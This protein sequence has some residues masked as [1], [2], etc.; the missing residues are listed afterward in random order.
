MSNDEE[1]AMEVARPTNGIARRGFGTAEI[2]H[3]RETQGSA[4]AARAQAEV[5]AR[6]IMAE[7]KP[8]NLETFRVKL[9]EH[10]KRQG[11]AL[12]AEYSK[13]VGGAPIKGP[14][15]RFVETALREYTNTLP[16]ETITYDDD[17]KRVIRVSVTDL[18][19][20]VTY[21]GD[22]VVEKTVERKK[23]K[24]S[25][26]IMSSRTN[27]YGDIVFKVRATE[28]D[29]ANK[30]A[31]ACSKKLRNLGLRI[32]PADIVDD[33]MEACR[34]TRQAKDA[35]DPVAARRS[36]IDAFAALGV[37]PIGL[38]EYLGHPF[39]QASPAEMDELRA[40]YATVKDGEAKWVDIVE[41]QRVRRGEVDKGSKDSETA[42]AKVKAKLEA[43]KAKRAES[44]PVINAE[45]TEGGK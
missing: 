5:Q 38:D 45:S 34:K 3:R 36:I 19:C 25:D 44:K 9:L 28:D 22:V 26:E 11:F 43:V 33:A 30:A 39:D 18:E 32:L 8:R 31:A 27:S 15:I 20:N 2:E 1:Q 23:P 4:L 12:V 10:C 17:H 6:Y 21:Y 37:T 7:R 13:P 16:E 29:F 35:Q 42:G 40:A 41:M 24:S 14:S